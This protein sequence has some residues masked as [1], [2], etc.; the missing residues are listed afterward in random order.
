MAQL[1]RREA[2]WQRHLSPLLKPVVRAH[3]CTVEDAL[4]DVARV[5]RAPGRRG[6]DEQVRVVGLDAPL[7]AL[8]LKPVGGELVEGGVSG[9]DRR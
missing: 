8:G 3:D 9:R 6:E 5:V 1:V 7:A 4:A 2:G